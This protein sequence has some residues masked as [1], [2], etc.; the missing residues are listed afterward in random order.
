MRKGALMR[1]PGQGAAG[2]GKVAKLGRV[3]SGRGRKASISQAQVDEIVH[4]T[5]H[6]VPEGETRW[7]CWTMDKRVG[8]SPAT[9]Q[10][11]WSAPGAQA[12]S[13]VIG[14]CMPRHR[15]L[16]FL[17]FLNKVDRE[18]PKGIDVHMI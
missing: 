10:R 13:K 12:G 15:H 11:V 6:T 2:P 17:E 18:T 14:S 4:P 3:A 16:G 7:S 8:L 5:L 1:R 9:V